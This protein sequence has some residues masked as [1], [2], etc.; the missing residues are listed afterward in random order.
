MMKFRPGT[1]S[2]LHQPLIRSIFRKND[3]F[4][5]K[6]NGIPVCLARKTQNA[7]TW[8]VEKQASVGGI[9]PIFL[10]LALHIKPLDY[11]FI[12]YTTYNL[13]SLFINSTRAW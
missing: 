12:F 7:P 10:V 11:V 6:M 9:L 4:S 8:Q 1:R 3:D 2:V 13:Y 5:E